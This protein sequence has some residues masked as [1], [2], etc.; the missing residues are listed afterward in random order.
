MCVLTNNYA[1]ISALLVELSSPF[2]TSFSCVCLC[3]CSVKGR[4]LV[5][6]LYD[7]SQ[8]KDPAITSLLLHILSQVSE[9]GVVVGG[10]NKYR[11]VWGDWGGAL[12][13]IQC[14]QLELLIIRAT[15][16]YF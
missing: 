12:C 9:C 5:S 14:V 7:Y 16:T 11:R 4:A 15:I 6:V 2:T 3:V 13:P 8:H 1:M 10:V